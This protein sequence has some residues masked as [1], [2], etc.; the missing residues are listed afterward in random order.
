MKKYL[1]VFLSVGVTCGLVLVL[2][3]LSSNIRDDA[4]SNSQLLEIPLEQKK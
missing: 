4:K 3:N 1:L 2:L